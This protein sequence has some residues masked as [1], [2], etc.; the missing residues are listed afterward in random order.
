[1]FEH[2]ASRVIFALMHMEGIATT[3]TEKIKTLVVSGGVAANKYSR[4]M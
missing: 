2:L 1:M 4:H 3:A